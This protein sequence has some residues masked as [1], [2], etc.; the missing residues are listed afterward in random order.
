[1]PIFKR[2]LKEK[3]LVPEALFRRVEV[4]KLLHSLEP[5]ESTYSSAIEALVT[6]ILAAKAANPAA[7]VAAQEREIDERVYALYGLRPEE[8]RMFEE[9]VGR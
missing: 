5:D 9:S 1:M 8:I 7:D 2:F 6:R 3:N 4:E